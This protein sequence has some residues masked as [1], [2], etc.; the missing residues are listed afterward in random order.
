[1]TVVGTNNNIVQTCNHVEIPVF[2]INN[3]NDAD[4]AKNNKHKII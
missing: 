1:M 4:V 2:V 3:I